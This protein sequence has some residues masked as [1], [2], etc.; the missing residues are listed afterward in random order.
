MNHTCVIACLRIMRRPRKATENLRF[1]GMCNEDGSDD[2]EDDPI[3]VPPDVVAKEQAQEELLSLK[4]RLEA[5]RK[6]RAFWKKL[7]ERTLT[8]RQRKQAIRRAVMKGVL[9][10][11]RGG[12]TKDMM[13]MNKCRVCSNR[14]YEAIK[15][16]KKV[17]KRA[18][19]LKSAYLKLR[20]QGKIAGPVLI[21]GEDDEK[22]EQEE[23]LFQ[24]M[25][26]QLNKLNKAPPSLGR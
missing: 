21:R 16:N 14:C 4:E 1:A 24:E 7:R 5:K 8:R 17:G 11:T 2:D 26:Q 18:I 9:P 12:L 23:L 25:Q 22:D 20:G 19:A 13:F 3:F 6:R 15:R 10:R